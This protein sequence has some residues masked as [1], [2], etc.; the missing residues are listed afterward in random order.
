MFQNLRQEHFCCRRIHSLNQRKRSQDFIGVY[1]FKAAL[2]SR[3]VR[4][5]RARWGF[6]VWKVL[7]ALLAL[8][9]FLALLGLLALLAL[10]VWLAYK[11]QPAR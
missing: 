4:D 8:L 5:I 9:E 11:V 6:R 10:L 1:A 3:H 2:Q 7:E